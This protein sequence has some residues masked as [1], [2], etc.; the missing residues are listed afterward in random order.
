MP[1]IAG[2][3][4][5]HPA[6][7]AVANTGKGETASDVGGAMASPKPREADIHAAASIIAPPARSQR[8]GTSPG[9]S[10]DSVAKRTS[11]RSYDVESGNV[12]GDSSRAS[13][14]RKLPSNDNGSTKESY[15]AMVSARGDL[16]IVCI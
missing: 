14:P 4:M 13:K 7:A 6:A 5:P 16:P 8:E 2:S 11:A 12:A 10:I 1:A 3:F 15:K 9:P